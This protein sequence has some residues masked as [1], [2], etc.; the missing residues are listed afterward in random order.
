MTNTEFFDRR[1]DAARKLAVSQSQ[2]L[3]WEREGLLRKITLPGIRAV[4][5][6]SREVA[7]L[8]QRL[9]GGVAQESVG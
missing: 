7:A 4:R 5:Y 6:D 3:K 1:R 8:A 9:L 2:I